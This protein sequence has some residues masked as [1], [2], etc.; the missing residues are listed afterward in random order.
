[1][2]HSSPVVELLL[3]Y[4]AIGGRCLGGWCINILEAIDKV[5]ECGSCWLQ[6]RAI[7]LKV[8]GVTTVPTRIG[9]R[10]AACHKLSVEGALT[11][12][13]EAR[14]SRPFW[15]VEVLPFG[16]EPKGSSPLMLF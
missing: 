16:R 15:F 3:A 13:A 2:V 1:V 4:L 12:L 14:W 10:L 9:E 6:L 11:W 7:V 8:T 5:G